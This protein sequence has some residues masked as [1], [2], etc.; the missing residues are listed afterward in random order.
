MRKMFSNTSQISLRTEFSFTTTLGDPGISGEVMGGG[1]VTICEAWR[2]RGR[3]Y[4]IPKSCSVSH[5]IDNSSQNSAISQ[6]EFVE[7]QKILIIK[8]NSF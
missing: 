5:I 4:Q 6:L 8:G 7:I 3:E 2:T 1:E